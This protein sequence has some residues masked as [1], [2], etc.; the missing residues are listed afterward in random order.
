MNCPSCL[1]R[2][3]TVIGEVQMVRVRPFLLALFLFVLGSVARSQGFVVQVASFAS[4]NEAEMAVTNLRGR[5]VEAS[6][7]K[8][9]APGTGYRVRVGGRFASD[10]QAAS[11]AAKLVNEGVVRQFVVQATDATLA[12]ATPVMP[13]GLL[14]DGASG[15]ALPART[16]NANATRAARPMPAA[17]PAAPSAKPAPR[18]YADDVSLDD[19]AEFSDGLIETRIDKKDDRLLLY[20]RNRHGRNLFRGTVRLTMKDSGSDSPQPWQFMLKPSEEGIYDLNTV[21]SQRGSYWVEVLDD[22]NRPQMIKAASLEPRPLK[23]EVAQKESVR[24]DLTIEKPE[25]DE[26]AP[27]KDYP[28]RVAATNNGDA[29]SADDAKAKGD[30]KTEEAPKEI[31][32]ENLQAGDVKVIVRKVAESPDNV[33]LEFEIQAPTPLGLISVAMQTTSTTD[34][35]QAIM[36]TKLGRIPFLVPTADTNGSFSFELKDESGRVLASGQKS[37]QEFKKN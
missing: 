37:F 11:Y 24:N 14:V 34:F 7:V 15:H 19:L 20:V 18:V 31:S 33:T 1:A 16:T 10:Q 9:D 12:T 28:M 36:T 27:P 13:A 26:D 2:A 8:S 6:V 23:T 5:G 25:V 22:R 17:L 35:K 29:P 21:I 30:G 4:Q 3:I 32:K